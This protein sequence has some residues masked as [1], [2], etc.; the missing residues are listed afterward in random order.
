MVEVIF[1]VL[2]ALLG[3]IILA[4]TKGPESA[5]RIKVI[6]IVINLLLQNGYSHKNYKNRTSVRLVPLKK[7]VNPAISA[8]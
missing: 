1:L 7:T 6:K 3:A 2:L 5:A 4:V 8:F